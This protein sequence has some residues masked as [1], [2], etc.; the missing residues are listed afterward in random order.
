M[1]TYTVN[2]GPGPRL[3][4][5]VI[6]VGSYQYG[7]KAASWGTP[8]DSLLRELT[9]LT[10][11]PLSAKYVARWLLEAD[12]S[13][14]PVKLGTVEIVLSPRTAVPWQADDGSAAPEQ[15]LF[16][17]VT[18][19]GERWFAQ[20]DAHE[21]N[22]ALLYF[23]GH[24]WGSSRRFLVMEDFGERPGR[25]TEHLIDFTETRQAMLACRATTQCFFLD[26]CRVDPSQLAY[27]DVR[28]PSLVPHEVPRDPIG[29]VPIR[30]PVFSS[31]RPGSAAR[32]EEHEITPF[33][34]A[35][36]RTL[37][38]LG[39]VQRGADWEITTS[40]LPEAL[41][42]VIQWFGPA[43]AADGF[44]PDFGDRWD[45]TVLR[46]LS[47]APLVPF[48]LSCLPRSALSS[49]NWMLQCLQSRQT[50]RRTPESKE[51]QSDAPA[52]SYR[53]VVTFP[54]RSHHRVTQHARVIQPPTFEDVVSVTHS[55]PQRKGR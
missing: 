24:G 29:M 23:C 10:C 54:D 9:D 38:G 53:L 34:D 30:N 12:W 7:G 28:A 55:P 35:L 31:A 11:A 13:T 46:R 32:A 26:A 36:V 50:L 14:G 20:C 3:H 47:Q 27:A 2:G 39:A 15:A 44:H 25:W 4:A 18:T 40:R 51:W 52:S 16:H 45:S 33:A 5:L 19:A 42:D 41:R 49:A 8:L 17:N 37:D 21:D 43:Y 6:G 22:I 1:T 48:K